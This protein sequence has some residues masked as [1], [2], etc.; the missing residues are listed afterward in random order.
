MEETAETQQ[1]KRDKEPDDIEIV[2]KRRDKGNDYRNIPQVT[3]VQKGMPLVFHALCHYS[4]ILL[5]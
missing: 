4:S 2:D 5:Y 3:P 1:Q